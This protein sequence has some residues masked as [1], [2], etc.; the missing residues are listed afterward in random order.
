MRR[1]LRDAL[2]IGMVLLGIACV[3]ACCGLGA[4]GACNSLLT[5][6]NEPAGRDLNATT[7]DPAVVEEAMA[8]GGIV[9]PPSATVL[10][11]RIDRGGPDT[12]VV[13]A[14]QM[15]AAD[16]DE[17]LIESRFTVP[18]VPG[19]SVGMPALLGYDPDNSPDSASA[20]DSLPPVDGRSYTVNR[21]V[22]VDR[23]DPARPIVH[24]WMSG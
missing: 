21:T 8:F 24:L 13:A 14:L 18:L 15:P 22:S 17:L 20:D 23:A 19:R 11:V 9:L 5:A 4:L 7:T 16:V 1:P 10:G 3:L 6:V 2:R 12:I